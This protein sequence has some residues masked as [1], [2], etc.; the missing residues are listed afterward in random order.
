MIVHSADAPCARHFQ[1]DSKALADNDP[2][3]RYGKTD[4]ASI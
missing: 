2:A 3:A 4:H 1:Y